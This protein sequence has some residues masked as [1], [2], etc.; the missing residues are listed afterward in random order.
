MT[1]PVQDYTARAQ[2]ATA[3]NRSID[4]FR[5]RAVVSLTCFATYIGHSL[6]RTRTPPQEV[7]HQ[8]CANAAR[9]RVLTDV[10]WVCP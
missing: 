1:I 6:G 2:V 9:M 4:W 7:K 5:T 8:S 10:W 3:V